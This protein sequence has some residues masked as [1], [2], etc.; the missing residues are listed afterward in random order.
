VT[1]SKLIGQQKRAPEKNEFGILTI[2]Q[3]P[4]FLFLVDKLFLL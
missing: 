4:P 3:V 2:T 1:P